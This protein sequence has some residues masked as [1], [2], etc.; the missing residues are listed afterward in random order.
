MTARTTSSKAKTP[1]ERLAG[2]PLIGFR[3]AASAAAM[4]RGP[5]KSGLPKTGA[6]KLGITKGGTA[7]GMVTPTTA[8]QR[9]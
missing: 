5:A 2:Q 6:T 7:F 9:D 8:T 1:R 3:T 4:R